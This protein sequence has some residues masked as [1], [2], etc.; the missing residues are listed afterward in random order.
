MSGMHDMAHKYNLI[1]K[2]LSELGIFQSTKDLVK[3]IYM[4]FSH[5]LKRHLKYVK[6]VEVMETKGI[7]LFKNIQTC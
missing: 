6:L 3:K 2:V 7:K 4:Y 5:S 1:Y